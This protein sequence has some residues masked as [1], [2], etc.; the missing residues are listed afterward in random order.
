MGAIIVV[1]I[2]IMTVWSFVLTGIIKNTVGKKLDEIDR[3]IESVLKEIE[4]DKKE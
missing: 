1:V 2:I 4:K 3:K